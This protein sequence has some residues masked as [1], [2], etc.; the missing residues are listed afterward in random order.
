MEP[1]EVVA[2][3]RK[4]RV[5]KAPSADLWYQR[6][7]TPQYVTWQRLYTTCAPQMTI[8]AATKYKAYASPPLGLSTLL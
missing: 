2:A 4:L 7:K 1:K 6:P 8:T 3:T 5:M